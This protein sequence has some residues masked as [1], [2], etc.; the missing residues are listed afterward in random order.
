[1]LLGDTGCPILQN[2]AENRKISY[3]SLFRKLKP[4]FI[5]LFYQK[6]FFS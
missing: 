6:M 3:E 4:R 1:M 5:N 2:Q